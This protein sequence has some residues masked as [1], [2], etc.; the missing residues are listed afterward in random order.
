MSQNLKLDPTKKDY[1]VV[2]GL[3]VASDRIEE[4]AY[5]ALLIPQGKWLYG[6]PD[7]G[8]LLYTLQNR[9]KGASVDGDFASFARDAVQRQLI[10]T[11]L[12]KD[13]NVVNAESTREGT[14]NQVQVVASES[15][16]SQQLKFNPV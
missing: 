5:F 12:A 14:S 10:A 8:S 16:L 9:R 15:Q 3:P 7:Q 13:V 1:V 6:A 11:G 4:Q 2:D